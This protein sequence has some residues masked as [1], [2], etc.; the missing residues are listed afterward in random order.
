MRLAIIPL[1]I[2][3][4]SLALGVGPGQP[5]NAMSEEKKEFSSRLCP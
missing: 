2:L 1:F 4:L 5:A 3:S